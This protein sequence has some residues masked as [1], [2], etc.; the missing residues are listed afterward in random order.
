MAADPSKTLS[1]IADDNRSLG[2]AQAQLSKAL[3]RLDTRLNALQAGIR[4][5]PYPVSKGGPVI[6]YKR[7][8]TGWHITTHLEGIAGI[9]S[10][11]PATEA[12]PGRQVELIPHIATLL[13]KISA[14]IAAQLKATTGAAK[15][16][17][18][19]IEAVEASR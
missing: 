4:I 11:T 19:L 18:K 3:T 2:L 10:E 6:G 9:T 17:D 7:F 13:E 12:P 1:K 8:S 14:A 16:A 15:D 5:E